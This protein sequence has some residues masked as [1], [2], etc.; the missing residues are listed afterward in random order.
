MTKAKIIL[1][2]VSFFLILNPV[3]S[4]ITINLDS[5]KG[6][7]VN[8]VQVQA[9]NNVVPFANH[10]FDFY[11]TNKTGATQDWVI[12]RKTISEPV[13]WSNYLCWSGLCYGSSADAV[14][15][16]GSGTLV[17][18][19]SKYISTYVTSSTQG[20][21]HY[22][23][24]I[25]TDET[26]FIDSVDLVI[27][28]VINGVDENDATAFNLFPNPAVNSITITQ[29]NNS[30]STFVLY[31]NTGKV[32]LSKNIYNTQSQIDVE[33]LK[34]GFYFYSVTDMNS[35]TGIKSTLIIAK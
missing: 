9:L 1:L 5:L 28:A 14:W 15:S 24:Y 19:E 34:S 23:Y 18:G 8:G 13:G 33:Q 2:T 12:T 16:S 17:D 22:R 21:S 30:S 7:V 29:K 35:G 10:I 27:S 26:N 20:N 3:S 4:Q 31:D 32:V 6:A 25:S 11:V